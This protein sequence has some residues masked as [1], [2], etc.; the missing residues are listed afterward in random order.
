M[1]SILKNY[2]ARL[3]AR[4]K[5]SGKEMLRLTEGELS[6][7]KFSPGGEI[8]PYYGLTC[9]AWVEAQSSLSQQLLTVQNSL[10]T[11]LTSAGLDHFFAFL[12]PTSFHMTICDIVAS[13][14]ALNS[15]MVK[16]IYNQIQA[17]FQEPLSTDRIEAHVSG[18]GLT[19][20]ITALV[21][22]QQETELNKILHLE[23]MIKKATRVNVRDFLG[24]I[25]L[26][27]GVSSPKSQIK[28]IQTVLQHFST[29]QF[30][31]LTISEF[32]LTY[33]T[34]M[35]TFT[36]LLTVNPKAGQVVEHPN[37]H[38]FNCQQP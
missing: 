2:E 21:H 22:F 13:K 4:A 12:D 35:N 27:Y 38:K 6:S 36:P 5:L 14:T 1:S 28:S 25:T 29:H 15:T 33:F 16:S 3:L 32:D 23:T 31:A 9:I 37:F 24:H 8:K 34:N 17:A 7:P 10:Q 26:A 30:G 18:L 19:S 20:T 11:Q